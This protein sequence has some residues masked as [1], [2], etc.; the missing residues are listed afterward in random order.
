MEKIGKKMDWH[1][2]GKEH[3]RFVKA[4]AFMKEILIAKKKYYQK[5]RKGII[6]LMGMHKRVGKNSS[7]YK[8]THSK[9]FEPN[10]LKIIFEFAALVPFQPHYL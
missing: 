4:S 8:F 3:S 7:I 2:I 1:A 9:S 6:F 5:K 10:L